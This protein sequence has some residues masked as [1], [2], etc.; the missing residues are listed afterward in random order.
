MA[1]VGVLLPGIP[2]RLSKCEV[3]AYGLLVC[4][5]TLGSAQTR[6]FSLYTS[7]APLP[8]SF[9]VTA[10][11]RKKRDDTVQYR[12][13]GDQLAL[14]LHLCIALSSMLVR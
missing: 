1:S 6:G 13:L 8:V 11:L 7:G 9:V 5:A 4:I 12:P 2:L 10:C 3:V 14:E